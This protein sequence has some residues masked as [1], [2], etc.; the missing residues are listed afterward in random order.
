MFSPAAPDAEKANRSA[1]K[2]RA[3]DRDL[4]CE[5]YGMA[6]RACGRTGSLNAHS[7]LALTGRHIAL[8]ICVGPGELA[9]FGRQCSS[10]AL[11]EPRPC[12]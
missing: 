11:L 8:R 1:A 10:E 6:I 12:R 5:Q 2:S 9:S 7:Q 4:T 3:I